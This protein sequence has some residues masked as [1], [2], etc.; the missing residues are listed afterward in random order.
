KAIELMRNL[1]I[2]LKYMKDGTIRGTLN[3]KEEEQPTKP[4][5]EKAKVPETIATA[6]KATDKEAEAEKAASS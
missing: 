4:V 5:E 3:L 6:E 2:K 1:G